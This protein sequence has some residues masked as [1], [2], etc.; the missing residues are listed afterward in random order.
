M[1]DS[2]RI[3]PAVLA[4]SLAVLPQAWPVSALA[5]G[6]APG[7]AQPGTAPQAA[8][9]R[10]RGSIVSVEGASM[11]VKSRDGDTLPVTLAGSTT[12]EEVLVLSGT[13]ESGGGYQVISA[14]ATGD[15]RRVLV[16]RGFVPQEARLAPRPPTRL[17][18]RG[19][20]HWPN[21]VNSSTPAPNL[22]ENIWFARDVPAMA[23]HLHAEPVLVVA[24]AIEGDNQGAAPIPV[25]ITGIPNNHLEYAVT[26]FLLAATFALMTLWAAWRMNRRPDE[27]AR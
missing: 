3:L 8:P 1:P 4:A 26:W 7:L 25:G 17:T 19:N 10:I 21:E 12:G 22:S 18:I 23:A 11:V 5:Q 14:F 24:A 20:L 16:D 13:R 2:S 6:V 15:G 9:V 27:G